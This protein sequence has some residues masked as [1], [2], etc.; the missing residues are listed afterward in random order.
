MA[1]HGEAP[2]KFAEGGKGRRDGR[3]GRDGWSERDRPAGVGGTNV[4]GVING[5]VTKRKLLIMFNLCFV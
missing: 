5:L 1:K 4:Y 2:I 3:D